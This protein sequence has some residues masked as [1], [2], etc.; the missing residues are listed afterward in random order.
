MIAEGS[1]VTGRL[2]AFRVGPGRFAVLLKDVLGVQDPAEI[3][4]VTERAVMFQD[5]PVAV[6]DARGLWGSGLGPSA[7]MTSLA[8]II[9]S[10]GGVATALV[11]DRIE[12]VVE[13]VEMRPLPALVEPFVRNV[14]SGVIMNEDGGRLVVDPA[15]LPGAVAVCGQRGP[16]TA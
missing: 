9:V 12:G 5:R 1:V 7:T 14:F 13:G 11:V 15:A 4:A 6:I 8:V 16:G 10:G 3:G 2:L